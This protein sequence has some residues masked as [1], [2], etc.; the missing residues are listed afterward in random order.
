MSLTLMSWSGPRPIVNSV[1]VRLFYLI[2][3]TWIVLAEF[4]SKDRLSRI[5]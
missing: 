5:R 3:N 1:W 4:F 2:C